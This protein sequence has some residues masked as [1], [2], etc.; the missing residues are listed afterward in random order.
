MSTLQVIDLINQQPQP[1]YFTPELRVLCPGTIYTIW[2]VEVYNND[3]IF[4]APNNDEYRLSQDT[5]F[6]TAGSDCKH[7]V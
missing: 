2:K 3:I 5:P 7:A 6:P 4:W 1:L